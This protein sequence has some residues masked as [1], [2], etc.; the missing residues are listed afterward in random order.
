MTYGIH[1]Y[2]V[3]NDGTVIHDDFMAENVVESDESTWPNKSYM[4]NADLL[5]SHLLHTD[6]DVIGIPIL[7]YHKDEIDCPLWLESK[8]KDFLFDL[9]KE[10]GSK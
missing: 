8:P 9:F 4:V 5:P 7:Q 2:W 10:L 6:D 3:M 1:K